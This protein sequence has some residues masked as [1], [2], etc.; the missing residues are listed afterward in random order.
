MTTIRLKDIDHASSA[1][2]YQQCQERQGVTEI[3]DSVAAAIASWWQS[4]GT[5]GRAFAALA[6]GA[7]VESSD[8]LD[9]VSDALHTASVWDGRDRL[10]L[11]MLATWA[12]NYSA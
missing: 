8:V 1:V 4:P 6:S 12:L 5:S 10:A 3:D 9:D 2:A 11:E 7:P